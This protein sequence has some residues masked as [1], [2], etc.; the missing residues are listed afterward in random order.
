MLGDGNTVI[1]NINNLNSRGKLRTGGF[2]RG[3]TPLPLG[4]QGI[5][6]VTYGCA[7]PC[8]P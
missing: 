7:I 8:L 2:K 3:F 5:G 1:Y 4:K 6:I